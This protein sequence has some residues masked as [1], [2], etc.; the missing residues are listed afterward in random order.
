MFLFS[1][2]TQLFA[3]VVVNPDELSAELQ[4]GESV[5]VPLQIQNTGSEAAFFSFPG[6]TQSRFA[7]DSFQEVS[8]QR[9]SAESLID[10]ATLQEFMLLRQAQQAI[11]SGNLNAF[12]EQMS[13]LQKLQRNSESLAINNSQSEMNHSDLST[14]SFF[15]DNFTAHGQEF[16]LIT[17]QSF[18]FTLESLYAD[19]VLNASSG[20]TWAN[21][22][23]IIFTTSPEFNPHHPANTVL[24]IGG[25][26]SYANDHISWGTGNSGHP[27]TEVITNLVF[28]NGY[29]LND[30]YVWLGNGWTQGFGTWSGSFGLNGIPTEITQPEFISS[31]SPASGSIEPGELLDINLVFDASELNEG[32]YTGDLFLEITGES[33]QL[34]QIPSSLQVS[35][36]P[37]LSINPA[38]LIF[39]ETFVGGTTSRFAEVTNTGTATASVL[40][41]TINSDHFI[42]DNG[43]FDLVPGQ[44]KMVEV[45]FAPQSPG[46]L[47]STLRFQTNTSQPVI[48]VILRA[49]AVIPGILETDKEALIYSIVEGEDQ[50]QSISLINSGESYLEYS[51]QFRPIQMSDLLGESRA[52]QNTAAAQKQFSESAAAAIQSGMIA[53]M[54]N[55]VRSAEMPAPVS[56]RQSEVLWNI[57]P[58]VSL[59]AF[60]N[61]SSISGFNAFTSDRFT[62]FEMASLDQITVYGTF[63][64]HHPVVDNGLKLGLAIYADNNGMPAGHPTDGVNNEIFKFYDLVTTE[65]VEYIVEGNGSFRITATLDLPTASGQSLNLDAGNY[66][67]V[68]YHGSVGHENSSWYWTFGFGTENTARFIDPDGYFH[69]GTTD[70]FRISDVVHRDPSNMAF[71][72]RGNSSTVLAANPVSGTISPSANMAVSVDALTADLPVGEYFY[73][74]EIT[75]NSP[76]SSLV[77]IPVIIMIHDGASG[78]QWANLDRPDDLEIQQGDAVGI[79]GRATPTSLMLETHQETA[80]EMMNMWVGISHHNSHP[81][82]WPESA[83]H[84]ATLH[85]VDGHTAEFIFDG[86]HQLEAGT[87]SYATRFQMGD[88]E[89]IYGGYHS[90]GGAFWME[91][92]FISGTLHVLPST[93]SEPVTQLPSA[94]GL[95]QNY[96]N[97]FN[98]VTN[99]T[100]SLPQAQEVRIDVFNIQGQRVATLVNGMQQAGQYTISFNANNLAS[101]IYIYKMQT[102]TFSQ[103]RKMTFVK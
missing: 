54:P 103:T 38:E 44:S 28:Q 99:I 35:G 92:L 52:P 24:Q 32:L 6:F 42:V 5:I 51:I 102:P 96:P 89:Y 76:A 2:S 70:W 64:N 18:S 12:P 26:I 10:D 57:E 82:E 16:V 37:S 7:V 29:E 43:G 17:N 69:V 9:R 15:F 93:S 81:A 20:Q 84:S 34:I 40:G 58:D 31:V 83:W 87:Y 55:R 46:T 85:A 22:L 45:I 48:T 33:E 8:A 77:E 67:L 98:P 66:W 39:G 78:L 49:S 100:Y 74:M 62:L 13:A 97:P 41:V 90:A 56:S 60:S 23:T 95:D 19:F 21:D 63:I 11:E 3:Q 30:V 59:N 65:G 101:G 91:N 4:S 36:I 68:A 61:H 25:L 79:F 1:F 53:D 27:G 75:T 88:N 86:T 14:L 94:F 72:I 80:F 47:N 73:M 50:S 71:T